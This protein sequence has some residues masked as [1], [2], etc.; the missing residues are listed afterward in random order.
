MKTQRKPGLK[1]LYDSIIVNIL[2]K[3]KIIGGIKTSV[4][5]KF[6]SSMNP[7]SPSF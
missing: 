4:L 6:G 5:L 1:R 3:C 2:K 7:K